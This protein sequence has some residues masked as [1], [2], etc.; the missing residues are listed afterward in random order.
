MKKTLSLLFFG[1]C[2]LL[3]LLP[4]AC[5]RDM[6]SPTS[7]PNTTPV[8]TA[9]PMPVTSAAVTAVNYVFNPSAVTITHGNAVAFE[10]GGGTHLL[11]IDNG[12]GTCAQNY[13]SWPQTIT[14]PTAG[15]FNF[16]CAYHSGCGT[17]SCSGCTG[18][19]GQVVVQ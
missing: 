9:T 10:L 3:V 12:A 8:P 7:V 15:T 6:A 16:H 17:T 19:V 1:A 11:Y 13:T 4:T 5:M 14:F 2:S 18:M